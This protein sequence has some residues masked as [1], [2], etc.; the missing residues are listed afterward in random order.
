MGNKHSNSKCKCHN[1]KQIDHK[2]SQLVQHQQQHHHQ[3]QQHQQQHQQ[4]SHY[5]QLQHQVNC[6]Q[7]LRNGHLIPQSLPAPILKPPSHNCGA[8]V[9]CG[10]GGTSL[11]T[12]GFTNIVHCG[13]RLVYF[14]I[15]FK[16]E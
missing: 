14:C 1:R 7:I 5:Q 12:R 8:R 6:N 15:D 3:Q 11:Y 9:Q 2:C 4:Q 13:D 16:V 10:G